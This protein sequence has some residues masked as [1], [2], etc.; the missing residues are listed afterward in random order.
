MS[1][2]LIAVVA[3]ESCGVL[4]GKVAIA[5]YWEKAL[6]LA[7]DLHFERVSTLVGADSVAIHYRG[8]RGPA[9]EVFFFNPAGLVYRASAHYL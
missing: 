7:P 1:S 6:A 4:D 5:R 2:P 8:P 9:I 3:Q